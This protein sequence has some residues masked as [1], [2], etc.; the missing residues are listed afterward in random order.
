M[1][2]SD[3]EDELEENSKE[4]L[5]FINSCSKDELVRVIFDMLQIK[6]I[7]K[8]EKKILEDRIRH[9]VV[10]CEDLIKIYD[11]FMTERI[12]FE[13]I[14]KVP[15]EQNISQ[16]KQLIDLKN[17]NYNLESELEI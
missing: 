7:L 16:M 9:Y 8:D 12:K 15:K 3:K 6:Q 11:L 1:A 17:K 2:N 10:G 13:K 5:D 4:L 14:F